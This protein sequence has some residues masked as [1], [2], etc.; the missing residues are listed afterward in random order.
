MYRASALEAVASRA[1]AECPDIPIPRE[2]LVDWLA[3]QIPTTDDPAALGALPAGD[4]LVAW[5]AAR[6]EVR[7]LEVFEARYL[8]EVPRFVRHLDGSARFADEVT[9]SVRVRLLVAE[10]DAVPR[11]LGYAG[12]G[13]LMA[14]VKI[15]AV[16]IA[17]DMLRRGDAPADAGTMEFVPAGED[18]ELD[19]IRARYRGAFEEALRAAFLGCSPEERTLLRL[20]YLDR[21]AVGALA[22]LSG[23]SISGM[24][25]RL[26]SLREG[27][28]E[29]T[30]SALA[31]QFSSPGELSS[32]VRLLDSRMEMSLREFFSDSTH[33]DAK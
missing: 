9:Q 12:Q 3:A 28:R 24:S 31:H 1:L 23:L 7:A 18:I 10:G 22:K 2:E 19:Y 17:L 13:P 26:T 29:R 30:R 20:L 14:F 16:R 33:F 21:L 5:A 27:L 25:R 32:L 6:G 15:C 8:S 11:L 4:L